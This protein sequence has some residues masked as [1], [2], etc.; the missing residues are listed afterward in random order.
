MTPN[1]QTN[2]LRD[3]QSEIFSQETKIKKFCAK[4]AMIKPVFLYAEDSVNKVLKKLK[5][6]HINACIVVTKEKKLIGKISD[7]D[8]IKLFLQQVE[9]EPLVKVLNI[10]YRREFLYNTAKDMVSK[11]K[12]FVKTHTP[13]NE[14]LQILLKGGFEYL[15]VLND[16]ENVVGV[17]TP[18]SIINLLKDY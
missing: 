15:P 6:E 1:K 2:S 13:I 11:N 16:N 7:N 14:I 4:D 12:S 8:I 17:I 5:K 3:H 18:S 9:Y 10:G